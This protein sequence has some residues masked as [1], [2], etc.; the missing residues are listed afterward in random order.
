MDDAVI[1]VFAHHETADLAVRRLVAAGCDKASL[2]V[3]GRGCH[4][5]Q[6]AIAFH[7]K[8]DCPSFLGPRGAFWGGLWGLFFGGLLLTFP[9]VGIVIVI[10]YL[11]AT[12]ALAV[13]NETVA[14]EVGLLG[15][16]LA[17]M[18]VSPGSAALYET[19]LKA[20]GFL[21][22][23]HGSAEEVAHA[24]TVLSGARPLIMNSHVAASFGNINL[25]D[26]RY[27]TDHFPFNSGARDMR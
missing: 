3:V 2:S 17:G 27:R 7:A 19:A 5:A 4:T 12:T 25:R 9:G 15:T 6:E 10:G 16:L 26:L 20:G 8:G 13:E 14:D 1:A 21:V 22:M 18:T 23:A 11:A 24:N